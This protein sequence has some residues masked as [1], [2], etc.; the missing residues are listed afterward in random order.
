[1]VEKRRTIT[2]TEHLRLI[3]DALDTLGCG[4]IRLDADGVK[5]NHKADAEF[6]RRIRRFTLRRPPRRREPE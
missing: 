3:A 5:R 4:Y 2:P 6:L 1:M